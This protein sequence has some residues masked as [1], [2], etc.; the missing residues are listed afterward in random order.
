MVA[1]GHDDCEGDLI[2]RVRG[3]VGAG[4]HTGVELDLHCHF[5]EQMRRHADAIIAYKEYPHTDILHRAIELS[6]TATDHVAGRI[7]RSPA[8]YALLVIAKWHPPEATR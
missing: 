2:E 8:M 3:I 5:S 7:S 6:R 1:D 4:V